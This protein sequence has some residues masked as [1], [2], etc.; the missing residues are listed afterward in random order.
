MSEIPGMKPENIKNVE[1][2]ENGGVAGWDSVGEVDF[3][4]DKME[5]KKKAGETAG[6]MV[7]LG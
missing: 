3:A 2:V 1:N 6:K 4:G 5:M 7:M